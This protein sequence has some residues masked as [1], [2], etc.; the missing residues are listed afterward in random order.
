M[1]LRDRHTNG[2]GEPLSERAGGGFDTGRVVV[3]G[4]TGR[5]RAKLAET[6]D[7]LDRHLLVTEEIKQ[8]IEQH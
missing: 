1:A 7:L 5:E 3:L 2:I 8:R 6:L 4:M